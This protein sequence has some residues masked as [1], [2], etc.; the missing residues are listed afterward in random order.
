MTVNCEPSSASDSRSTLPS[1]DLPPSARQSPKTTRKLGRKCTMPARTD[2]PPEVS[3]SNFA[4]WRPLV[5]NLGAQGQTEVPV[6]TE[7]EVRPKTAVVREGKW[8]KAEEKVQ[9]VMLTW[10]EDRPEVGPCQS[11]AMQTGRPCLGPL[12]PFFLRL[13]GYCWLPIRW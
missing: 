1:N 9:A 13:L 6:A 12:G 7:P 10:E 8:M 5:F 4:V 11:G 2:E 3:S